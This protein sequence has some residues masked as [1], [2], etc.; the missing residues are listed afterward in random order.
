MYRIEYNTGTMPVLRVRKGKNEG[1]AFAVFSRKAPTVLGRSEDAEICLDDNRCSR[2]HA[3]AILVS[4]SW[5]IEDL[6]SSNGTQ[7]N[8]EK[9]DRSPLRDQSTVQIGNTLLVFEETENLPPPRREIHG[10]RLL[11]TLREEG[12]VFVYNAFQA[13]LDRQVRVDLFAEGQAPEGELLDRI[14]AAVESTS[15]LKHDLID[16]AVYPNFSDGSRS[17][18]VHRSRGG[19]PLEAEF[20]SIL[21]EPLDT[22]LGLVRQLLS[23]TLTRCEL[24]GICYPLSLAQLQIQPGGGGGRTLSCAALELPTLV[25]I[26][27][28]ALHH[29]GAYT[30]YLPPELT[31]GENSEAPA[32]DK[33]LAYSAAALAYYLLTGA[34]VMGEGEASEI[35]E[36]HRELKPAPANL[37]EADIPENLSDLLGE[38]LE[39]DPAA[40]PS[41]ADRLDP[42]LS[43]IRGAAEEG[44]L[45]GDPEPA[46]GHPGEAAEQL[47]ASGPLPPLTQPRLDLKTSG[48]RPLMESTQC[49]RPSLLKNFFSLPF[50]AALWA[51]LFWGS[52]KVAEILFTA[53]NS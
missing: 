2:K 49:P 25:S 44:E 5:H 27:D 46:D 11:D 53:F 6:G 51:A 47:Q 50:W 38:M 32:L 17:Y 13:A 4:G 28:N 42:V 37:I 40:R 41:T 23:I 21:A 35:L 19:T 22:R 26:H 24:P 52:S 8:G 9:V 48:P 30:D 3:Q 20:D 7:L 43:S 39:K 15:K 31:T 36:K 45:H 14:L 10:S 12:C 33:A 34:P 16:A 18:L 29:L 1:E